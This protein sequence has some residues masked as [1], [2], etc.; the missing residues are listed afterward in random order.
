VDKAMVNVVLRLAGWMMQKVNT[1]CIRGDM[2]VVLATEKKQ[3]HETERLH[4]GKGQP[5]F[6]YHSIFF[7]RGKVVTFRIHDELGD[8]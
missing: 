5:F 7:K 3:W 4:F 8:E 1:Y 6:A 2:Q